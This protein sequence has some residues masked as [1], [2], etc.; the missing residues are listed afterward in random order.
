MP[1]R[2][3]ASQPDSRAV[4]VAVRDALPGLRPAERRIATDLLAD[5]DR[6]A[7]RSISETA[8]HAETSTTTVVRFYQRIGYT[9]FKDLRHDLAQESYRERLAHADL[10]AEASDI[11]RGDTLEQVVAKVARDETL[12]I[13]DTAD[14]L[15][16]AVLADA[17]RLVAGARRVD[18]F[19][20]GAS[21]IAGLDLQ[22]KLT[23]I[24]RTAIDWAES[25]VAWTSAAVLGPEGVAVAI[26]HSGATADTIEFLR[27]ARASGARTIA[28]TN[29]AGSP[30]TEQADVVLRTAARET[31]FRSGALGSRIA[32][33]M[34]VDCLFVGVVQSTYDASMAAIRAT[35]DAVQPQGSA[36][37]VQRS[38]H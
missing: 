24:G 2:A 11:A 38:A 28:I 35:Y 21:A 16:V 30:L 19:G 13:G 22:R 31:E 29:F 6:F 12:S 1:R 5:P 17:V 7:R 18:T 37:R 15:D 25:H 34:I 3:G 36:R 9:R 8:T 27:L 32:Q 20:I 23:R 10:P 33:L 4:L 26:S 14:L